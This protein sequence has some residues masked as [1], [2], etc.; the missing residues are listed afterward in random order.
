MTIEL[1]EEQ[2][3]LLKD[4]MLVYTRV[5]KEELDKWQRRGAKECIMSCE[6]CLKTTREIEEKLY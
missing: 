3:D 6:R 1:N 4:A 5:T 2:L